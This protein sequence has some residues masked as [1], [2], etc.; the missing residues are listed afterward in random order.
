M[1]MLYP[2]QLV[3]GAGCSSSALHCDDLSSSGVSDG[4]FLVHQDTVWAPNRI[5]RV[6]NWHKTTNNTLTSFR[7]WSVASVS[8]EFPE[9]YQV[10]APGG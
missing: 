10:R 1:Q 5:T 4:L 3:D 6:G 7:L 2:D 8:S 9:M